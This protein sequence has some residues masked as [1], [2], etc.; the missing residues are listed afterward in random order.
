MVERSYT[1]AL[2]YRG[3]VDETTGADIDAIVVTNA[4]RHITPLDVAETRC[5]RAFAHSFNIGRYRRYRARASK[6][7]LMLSFCW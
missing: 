1:V 4:E 3:A 5:G 2:L 7:L 6:C